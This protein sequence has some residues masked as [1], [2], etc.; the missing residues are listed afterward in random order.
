MNKTYLHKTA[1]AAMFAALCCIATMVMFPTPT[2]G[3]VH[4]GDAI[5]LI[6][7]WMLGPVYGTFAAALGSA[8]ADLFLGYAVYAPGTFVIKAL[9]AL[10]A[11]F[12]R[13]SLNKCNGILAGVFSAVAAEIIMILGYFLYAAL[14]FGEGLAAFV[15]TVPPNVVQ[16]VFGIAVS[17][18]LFTLMEKLLSKIYKG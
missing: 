18:P 13:K 6:A 11:W 10:C 9:V 2:G 16:G 3:Y 12:L 1:M 5:V 7:G 4:P 17:V 8:L 15:S 14:V